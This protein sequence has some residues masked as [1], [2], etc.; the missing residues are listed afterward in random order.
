MNDT[1]RLHKALQC[2]ARTALTLGQRHRAASIVGY[3]SSACRDVPEDLIT[4]AAKTEE[5]GAAR[6]GADLGG[7]LE[8]ID[9]DW[10][11]E[12]VNPGSG[13]D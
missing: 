4:E 12:T 6:S 3:L 5:G 8:S 11:R 7:L 1:D 9:A 2:A 10:C 13:A